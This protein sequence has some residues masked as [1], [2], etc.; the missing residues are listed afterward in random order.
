M[1][2]VSHMAASNVP[3]A[4]A[5]DPKLTHYLPDPLPHI[6]LHNSVNL[7]AGASGVGKT[8]FLAGFLRQL[9]DHVPI[10]DQHPSTLP[11]IGYICA[12]R[13]W[14]GALDWLTRAGY[15]DIAHYSLIDDQTFIPARLRRKTDRVKILGECLA[16]LD[17][18]P[19]GSLV[20]VDPI[21]LFLGGNLN[22]FDTC[23]VALIEIRRMCLEREITMLGL[24]HSSKQKADRKERYQ[25]L[26]D[27]I[28][29]SMA[30]HG[31]GD[32]QMYLA[33]PEEIGQKYYAFLWHPHQVPAQTFK[34]DR[35]PT[36][37]LFIP[38]AGPDKDEDPGYTPS[39]LDRLL[40]RI[41]ATPDLITFAALTRQVE[42]AHEGSRM[43][44]YRYLL[45]LERTGLIVKLGH[46]QYSRPRPS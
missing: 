17:P 30:L 40:H 28:L 34:L 22:D 24:A 21:G 3:P 25:R 12:D 35:D 8:A 37:G 4:P 44:V 18:L 42:E 27:R 5:P 41:P 10:F 36:T 32:T 13:S 9:R 46:G 11:K 33:S 19:A 31:Y 43:T 20:A 16:K 38:Y 6:L 29:G 2:G 26:Q 45:E 14:A 15:P 1:T 7:L 23:G 39:E